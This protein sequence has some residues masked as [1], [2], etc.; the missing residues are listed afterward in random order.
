VKGIWSSYYSYT[1]D[2]PPEILDIP[3]ELALRDSESSDVI[4]TKENFT[5]G[6]IERNMLVL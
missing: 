5:E 2:I 3:L 1:A 4:S 6:W